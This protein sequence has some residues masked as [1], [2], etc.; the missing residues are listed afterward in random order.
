MLTS[1]HWRNLSVRDAKVFLGLVHSDDGIEGTHRRIATARRH[2]D[3]FGIATEC[4]FGRRPPEQI[5]EL[6][7]IHVQAIRELQRG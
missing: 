6:L 4:G 3:T 1:N 5:P 7:E 2:L